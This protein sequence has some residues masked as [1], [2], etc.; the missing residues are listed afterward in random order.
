M[1]MAEEN[2]DPREVPWHPRFAKAV[3]GHEAAFDG[4]KASFGSGRPHHAWLLAGPMGIGKATLA[5]AMA[6]HVLGQNMGAA[7]AER[8]V[9]A[10]AHPD[11]AVLER[12]LNDAKPKKKLKAE[13]AV[14]NAREFID[15]FGRTSGGGGW[16][17][18]LVDAADDLNGESANALLKLVEEPPNK[19][20]IL[21]VCHSPGR[22]LR[23]LRSRCRRLPLSA[24]SAEQSLSVLKEIPADATGGDGKLADAAA[25]S[26]GSPGFALQLMNSEGAKA[27]LSFTTAKRLDAP[28]RASI[29]QHFASRAAAVQDFEVF[30]GLLLE[31]VANRAGLRSDAKLSSLHSQLASQQSIVS[32]YN[33][34]RRTAVMDALAQIDQALK[35]A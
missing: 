31:W 1:V 35:A 12:V 15:F 3:V 2:E 19:S 33:L 9:H 32:G 27:F 10:R 5:Y 7:Q 26:G 28:M 22:L 8:W 11:L 24:L 16:R 13:I 30:M 34:D 14:D 17:V 20:V 18:G 4:F 29:G 25:I 23:T 21:L 6:R